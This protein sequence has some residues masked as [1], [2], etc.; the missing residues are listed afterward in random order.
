M[1]KSSEGS[2]FTRVKTHTVKYRMYSASIMTSFVNHKKRIITDSSPY[3]TTET[4]SVAT[5]SATF[6][7]QTARSNLHTAGRNR[8]YWKCDNTVRGNSNQQQLQQTSNRF[9]FCVSLTKTELRLLDQ[10]NVITSDQ[11]RYSEDSIRAL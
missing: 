11:M 2:T 7:G 4:R 10:S 9:N 3:N 6:Q 5:G 8:V 1:R